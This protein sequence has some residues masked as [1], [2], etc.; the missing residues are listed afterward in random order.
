MIGVGGSNAPWAGV[1]VPRT[2]INLARRHLERAAR[3]VIAVRGP[4]LRGRVREIG[5]D[6]PESQ[7][8]YGSRPRTPIAQSDP[9]P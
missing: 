2:A 3:R 5:V 6:G 4:A 8:G 1:S 7:R 9:L